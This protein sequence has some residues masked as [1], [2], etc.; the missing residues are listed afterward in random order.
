MTQ[1]DEY[2][3]GVISGRIDAPLTI[4]QAVERHLDDL[5][6][7]KKP[8][9]RYF[10]SR[11]LADHYIKIVRK[12]RHTAGRWKGRLFQLQPFQAFELAM[13]F[14]WVKKTDGKRRFIRSY[15]SIPRKNGKTELLAA[16]MVLMFLYDGENQ[17]NTF[18][19]AT[20]KAQAEHSA[21]A[22]QIM[23]DYVIAESFS[24][25]SKLDSPEKSIR[26]YNRQDKGVM[27]PLSRQ[28][29]GK[30]DGFNSHCNGVDELHAHT[31]GGA[32]LNVLSSSTGSREQP[33]T[34]ITTTAGFNR[35]GICFELE[36]TYKR[37]LAGE[38]TEDRTLIL[39]YTPDEG[40]QPDD[41]KVWYK[42]N[43]N[44]GVS[45]Q[46][47]I[48]EADFEAARNAG[49]LKWVEFLTKRLNIWTDS[50]AQWLPGHILDACE[51]DYTDEQLRGQDCFGGLDLAATRDLC[52]FSLVFPGSDGRIRSRAWYFIP[53]DNI[54]DRPD[55]IQ[56]LFKQW[57]REGKLIATPGNV[58]DYEYIERKIYEAAE[59]Y[60]LIEV[61]YDRFNASQLIINIQKEGIECAGFGQG[62]ISMNAPTRALDT[63][64]RGFSMAICDD[65][66]LRWAF[67]NV[68]MQIDAAENW[69]VHKGKSTER[70]DPVVSQIMALGQWMDYQKRN[71]VEDLAGGW[72]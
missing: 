53:E 6:R 54:K 33:L 19:A 36:S 13:T 63:Y 16:I 7:S 18:S 44:M 58:T 29:D 71:P 45:I 55:H 39:I 41:P 9:Y 27:R 56:V 70:V 48:Y 43:P 52:S 42:V 32:L 26:V 25:R 22:A 68:V 60:N 1:Y 47:D 11:T 61:A 65:P 59:K 12:L 17:A 35:N 21:R 5:E 66:V 72:A 3:D 46:P 31:D 40:D 34:K 4:R 28:K 8:S 62:F 64:Y 37:V 50:F 10:F 67:G 20:D 51:L 69:K 49:G 30:F 57:I 15:V 24:F 14:G 23:C 38:L 2:I